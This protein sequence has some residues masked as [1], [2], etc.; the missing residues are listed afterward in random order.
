MTTNRYALAGWASILSAAG[1]LAMLGLSLVF[2]LA[3]IVET[4]GAFS[5]AMWT[6]PQVVLVVT[7]DAFAWIL[8]VYALIRFRDLVRE[9][10]DF[11]AI[12]HLIW[13][14]IGAGLL[15]AVASHGQ[16]IFADRTLGDA[17]AGVAT[18]A[19]LGILNGVIGIVFATRLLRINGNLNGYKKPLAYVYLAGSICFLLVVPSLVGI[20]LL[21]AWS[22]LLGLAFFKGE[23]LEELEELEVV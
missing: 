15:V 5:P 17:V 9:R 22:I 8:G 1:S 21:S 3:K 12:D 18:M 23:E 20:V 10:Y 14:V 11:H 13:I 19:I 2:D 16:R 4:R 7:I 6:L